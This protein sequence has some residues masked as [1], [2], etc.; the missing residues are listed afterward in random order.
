MLLDSLKDPAQTAVWSEFDARFRPLLTAFAVRLGL[1]AVEAEDAA[2]ETLVEFVGAYRAGK[3]DRSKGRLSSWI[4]SIAH[5]RIAHRL[6]VVGR[7]AGRRGESALVDLS[8]PARLTAVW[9]DE[10]QRLIIIRAMEI[11][12]EG[13]TAEPTIRA[14]DLF[15]V[16]GVAAEE[17]AR[18]CG[19]TVAE[20]YTA[21]NRVA[22]RLRTIIDELTAAW[23]EDE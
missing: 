16:R 10:Q 23:R 9:Q 15:A 2:Q 3:Y 8:D 13:K 21:K 11:L 18:E 19:M 4:I 17:V 6:Q 22:E 12:R 5:H 1:D 14:F 7:A 20:V